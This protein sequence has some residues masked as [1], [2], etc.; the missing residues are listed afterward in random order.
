MAEKF[1]PKQINE[2]NKQNLTAKQ[3]AAL[4]A[5]EKYGSQR[6]AAKSLGLSRS[7]LQCHLRAIERHGVVPY[8][9]PLK[10][11]DHMRLTNTTVEIDAQGKVTREWRRLQ[12]E[13][14]FA[15]EVVH[16]LCEKVKGT[17]KVTPRRSRK[18]DTD[19]LLF[20]LDIFDP[21]VGMFASEKETLDS[22]YN[23]NIATERMLQACYDLTDRIKDRRPSK[24]VLVFGGDIM[25]SDFRSN[26]TEH[27]GH[28]LDV[29]SRFDRVVD[30]T[31][32]VI[33]DC[34]KIAAAVADKVEVIIVKGNHDW[35]S[36]V[37][38]PRVIA[39]K[40]C[41]SPN[42]SVN[43]A[44]SPRRHMVWGN[45]LL[46]WA[47]GDKVKPAKWQ[48]LVAAELPEAWGNTRWRYLRLGHVHHQKIIA[49][50]QIEEQEG[51]V[52]EYLPALC[53]ADAWHAES[54]YIG[55]QKGAS[56]FEYHRD[57]GLQTRFYHNVN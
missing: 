16:G 46:V 34:V 20:E 23:C 57:V 38:L 25:H 14:L 54:G 28:V 22:D 1:S 32:A 53:P 51:I 45:N 2:L 40:Y 10:Q 26:R 39:A 33:K 48:N 36:C 37:W 24:A 41:N 55:N 17:G 50:I 43:L 47:H 56:A 21:H 8:L 27:S 49:P 12:P 3:K 31:I 13:L 6:A 35:H 30:Y 5:F 9:T 44:R 42:V 7:A 19:E 29:D 15:E 4:E 52:V 11:P 18:T